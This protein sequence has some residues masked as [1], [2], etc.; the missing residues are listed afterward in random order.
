VYG[1][2][3]SCPNLILSLGVVLPCETHKVIL[4]LKIELD[5]DS[6]QGNPT[7]KDRIRFR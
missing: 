7:P 3:V 6:S 1:Y 4:H 5:L 2:L